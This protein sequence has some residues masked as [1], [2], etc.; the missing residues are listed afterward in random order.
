M[1]IDNP[2]KRHPILYTSVV[3]IVMRLK[4]HA[5]E[6]QRVK[7]DYAASYII[8]MGND[9]RLNGLCLRIQFM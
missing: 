3:Y 7:K 8:G 5:I 1:K 9:K 6:A 4:I 2:R